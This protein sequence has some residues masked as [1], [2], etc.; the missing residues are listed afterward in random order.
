MDIIR[1]DQDGKMP[2]S[3]TVVNVMRQRRKKRKRA[4]VVCT[5][6]LL[7]ISFSCIIVGWKIN[8]PKAKAVAIPTPIT[9]STVRAMATIVVTPR[10]GWTPL[11]GN[12]LI[13]YRI[14]T[15]KKP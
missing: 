13:G 5:I 11:P 4:L 9:T 8:K 3:P 14:E 1:P 15:L 12:P 2:W 6:V 7:A 10:A